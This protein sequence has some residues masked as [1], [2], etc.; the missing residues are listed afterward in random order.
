MQ[1]FSFCRLERTAEARDT[2]VHGKLSEMKV[3][4]DVIQA[5]LWVC[6]V[7]LGVAERRSPTRLSAT[8]HDRRGLES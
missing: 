4:K 7:S 2:D 1:S 8:E 3:E 5:T 6:A